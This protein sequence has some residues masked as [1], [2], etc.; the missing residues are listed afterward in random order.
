M[1]GHGAMKILKMGLV[2]G[3]MAFLSSG[4]ASNSQAQ[5]LQFPFDAPGELD[6]WVFTS[7]LP[8]PSH[9]WDETTG[10]GDP[11]SLLI[12]N[13]SPLAAQ[14]L[15]PCYRWREG[16]DWHIEGSVFESE[17]TRRCS[18]G[19]WGYEDTACSN[20]TTSGTAAPENEEAWERLTFTWPASAWGKVP[21]KALRAQLGHGGVSVGTGEGTCHYDDIIISSPGLA[22]GPVSVPM[23]SPWKTVL[24]GLALA[25]SALFAL[26]RHS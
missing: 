11:G 23:L 18:I 2:I 6:Y 7:D 17:L 13:A 19:F 20:V 5:G 15:S 10:D 1:V 4:W 16:H 26:R 8:G 24:L 21:V 22:A 25:F 12:R 14:A 3:L 9:E